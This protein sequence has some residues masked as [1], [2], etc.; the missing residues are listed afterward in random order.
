MILYII[1]DIMHDIMMSTLT[2]HALQPPILPRH[3][4]ATDDDHDPDRPMDFDEECDFA[5]QGPLTDMYMEEDAEM[6]ALLLKH[7]PSC[8]DTADIEQLVRDIPVQPPVVV[9]VRTVQEAVAAGDLPRWMRMQPMYF[10]G[11]NASCRTMS[12]GPRTKDDQRIKHASA[13]TAVGHAAGPR[14]RQQALRG[15]HLDVAPRPGPLPDV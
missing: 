11:A 6:L 2:F 9:P 8:I 13:D 15:E 14:Q 4:D 5:D 10:H 3:A 12:V 7:M 1:N